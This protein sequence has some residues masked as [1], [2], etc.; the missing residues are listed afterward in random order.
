[1]L[2]KL[3]RRKV[4]RPDRREVLKSVKYCLSF[5][6][7]EEIDFSD[8]TQ[9][10]IIENISRKGIK[11]TITPVFDKRLLKE[12]Q[13]QKMYVHVELFL[14]PDHVPLSLRGALRW[15]RNN[16]EAF[17]SVTEIG[18]EFLGLSPEQ[19]VQ[20]SRYINWNRT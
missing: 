14:P 5:E 2:R 20:I 9:R 19:K 8:V 18:M 13:K 4:Q 1:M 6:Q 15:V 12:I 7:E 16:T 3:F 10:A 17:P 11:L